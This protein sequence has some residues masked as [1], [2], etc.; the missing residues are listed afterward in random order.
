M[1]QFLPQLDF[2]GIAASA[3]VGSR[4]ATRL[5]AVAPAIAQ[6][7]RTR[8]PTTSTVTRVTSAAESALDRVAFEGEDRFRF[9]AVFERAAESQ[10]GRTGSHRTIFGCGCRRTARTPR[11]EVVH[12]LLLLVGK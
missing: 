11:P 9:A 8:A 7:L 4:S 10:S 12:G 5:V 6:H 1:R 3:P 2:D